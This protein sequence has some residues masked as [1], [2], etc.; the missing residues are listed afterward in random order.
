MSEALN[1][2]K[3][4]VGLQEKHENRGL[5]LQSRRW[6]RAPSVTQVELAASA[7]PLQGS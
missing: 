5:K 4:Q 7:A 3:K 6:S 1:T 2:L